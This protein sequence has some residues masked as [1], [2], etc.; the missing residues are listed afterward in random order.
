MLTMQIHRPYLIKPRGLQQCS[1][2]SRGETLTWLQLVLARVCKIRQNA[3]DPLGAFLP[4]CVG[5]QQER[6]RLAFGRR[7][8]S[9]YQAMLPGDGALNGRVQ[10]PILV[11]HDGELTWF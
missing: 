7:D 2:P 5:E 11:T 4:E 10:F 9:E 1:D 3:R 6:R 8:A